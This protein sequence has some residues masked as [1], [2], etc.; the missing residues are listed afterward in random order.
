MMVWRSRIYNTVLCILLWIIPLWGYSDESD[1]AELQTPLG[2]NWQV[3][4]N[5]QLRHIKTYARLEDGKRYRSFKVEAQL[6]VNVD[7]VARLMLDFEGYNKW[8]WSVRESH[9]LKQISPT[10][11]YIYM[12]HNAPYGM[13]DRDVILHAVIEPQTLSK[14]YAML[15]VSAIPNYLPLKPPFVRMTAEEMSIRFTPLA[16]NRLQLETEGYLEPGG[17]APSWAA[18]F[19]QRSAP[20]SVI[21]GMMRML[22]KNEY[23]RGDTPLPFRVYRYEDYH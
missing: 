12:V 19:I 4:R 14:R 22:E 10:E 17:T 20:Y 16:N 13:P 9:L 5:D 11:Y 15:H 7:T 3:V 2:Q 8:Y 6:G 1:L 18:N 23:T 21:L